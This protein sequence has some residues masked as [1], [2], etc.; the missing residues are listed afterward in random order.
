MFLWD[1]GFYTNNEMDELFDVSYSAVSRKIHIVR[2][3]IEEDLKFKNDKRL[4][5]QNILIQAK[6]M[7]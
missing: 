5:S 7:N 1:T 4:I 2:A 6:S 3:N